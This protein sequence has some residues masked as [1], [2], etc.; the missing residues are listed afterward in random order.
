MPEPPELADEGLGQ[1]FKLSHPHDD[2]GTQT[3]RCHVHSHES[4]LPVIM[5]EPAVH[6]LQG[7]RQSLM[8]AFYMC[9]STELVCPQGVC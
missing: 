1:Y 7:P 8:Y 6:V 9:L 4:W 5:S 3:T 2:S